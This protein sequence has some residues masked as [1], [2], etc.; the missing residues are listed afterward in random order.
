MSFYEGSLLTVEWTNQHG[1]GQNPKLYCNMVMQYMCSNRDEDPKSRVRDGATT[2]TITDDD[3]GAV[4][5][6]AA[7]NLLY[8]MHEPRPNYQACA[9]R[10]RNMGLFI[11]DR[12]KE[13]NIGGQAVN[14]RQNNGGNRHG[15]ECAE[16]RDYYPYWHPS[17]WKD[18]AI[19]TYDM[20][21]CSFYKKES[22]N[23]K[24]RFEC[25]EK[26]GTPAQQNNEVACKGNGNEWLEVP[27]WNIPA[28]VCVQASWARDNHLGNSI[29]G[30]ASSFNW[31]LPLRTQEGCVEK[32]NCNC[33]LRL[34]YNISTTDT[35]GGSNRP[36][37]GFID[38]TSNA[39]NSPV[40]DDPTMAQDG[41]NMTMAIDTTQFGRTFQDRS[42]VFHIK[43]RP[44]SISLLQRIFNL[45]VRGKRGNIV[46][47]YPATE[48]DFVPTF[49]SGR[50][51]DYIHFQWTGCDTNPNGNAGEG[52]AATDRSNMVQ[53]AYFD[54]S[55]PADDKWISSNTPLFESSSLRQW[56]SQL[57]QTGCLTY[58]DL[59]KKNANNQ[60]NIEQDKANCMKLNA[61]PTGYFDGGLIRMNRTGTFYY[62]SSRNNNFSN[63]GQK[64]EMVIEALLPVWATVIVVVGAGFFL[65]SGGLAGAMLYAKAHPHSSI[66][67]KLS[68][69]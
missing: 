48:Y 3:N 36:D 4:A 22:Q 37:A 20:S 59:A 24:S 44:T 67:A 66:A 43:P 2:N 50:Q 9:A 69:I 53:L 35:G 63:R 62:M 34:R 5:T 54:A 14:T 15:Y 10:Q 57:G 51:G 56:M 1:C 21:W 11:A 42:H 46:Q 25:R 31:T 58:E 12:A 47:A 52:T 65:A 61:A 49:F 30:F 7:G 68:K 39:G 55:L 26:D 60:N 32:D 23:V 33:V 16:E 19:M 40:T 6:D 27:P 45:N 64:G 17:S 13:G 41:L 38:W 8:G 28:P 18:V 29:D